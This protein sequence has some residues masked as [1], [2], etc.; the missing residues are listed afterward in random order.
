MFFLFGVNIK[1]EGIQ[2]E[3]S[4]TYDVSPCEEKKAHL[5]MKIPAVTAMDKQP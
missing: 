5:F 3:M 2:Q 1:H 4:Q